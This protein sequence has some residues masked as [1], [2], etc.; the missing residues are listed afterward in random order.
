MSSG[1]LLTARD[2]SDHQWI[3]VGSYTESYGEF[4]ARGGG[5]SILCL[6]PSGSLRLV[7][8]VHSPNPSYLVH[9]A[10]FDV[11]H[12]TI[13][14]PD[15]RAG[16][17]SL[18]TPL[19]DNPVRV[20]DATPL[21][22]RLPCHIDL[23]P[24]GRWIACACYGSGDVIVKGISNNGRIVLH[25]GDRILRVGSGP[26]P[27]RQTRSHPHG[28]VFSPDGRWLLVPDLGTDQLAAYPFD[29]LTG[30]L[31]SPR[32]WH[33]PAGSGPRTVAYSKC[34]HFILLTSELSSE[35]SMLRW[36]GGTL[37]ETCRVSSRDSSTPA[38]RRENTAAG[39]RLHPD[40]IHVGVTNR[41]DDSISVFG[42]DAGARSLRRCQT[43][44]SGGRKPRDI[45]FSPCG[46]W[47]ISA[48]QD[49]D[50]CVLFGVDPSSASGFLQALAEIEVPSPSCVCFLSRLSESQAASPRQQD[51]ECLDG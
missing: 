27:V 39:L 26:H 15:H 23:H 4:R 21:K 42:M 28:A 1:S 13:E 41:G 2:R 12:A 51:D 29:V 24:D 17:V 14:T 6:S 33:A 9:L 37:T 46:R 22:G 43:L 20:A 50:S 48:N 32:N 7:D 36:Q 5:V 49:S 3:A 10:A 34:G 45:G 47:L 31:G 44:P 30:A 16:L 35:V 11:L 38:E 18:R 40:G 8:R 19:S 25:S